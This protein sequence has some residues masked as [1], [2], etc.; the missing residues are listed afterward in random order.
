[1]MPAH[2]HPAALHAAGHRP[3]AIALAAAQ[4]LPRATVAVYASP[5]SGR[6]ELLMAI[7]PGGTIAQLLPAELA[8]ECIV[9]RYNGLWVLRAEWARPVMPGDMIEWHVRPQGGGGSDPLRTILSIALMVAAVALGQLYAP[10]LILAG[11]TGGLTGATV[12]ALITAGIVVAGNL[13]I[14]ALLPVAQAQALNAGPQASPSYN[15]TLSGNAARLDGAIPVLYGYNRS[16]PDFAGQPYVEYDN[17]TSDQYYHA[18]LAVA[19]GSYTIPRIEIDDTPLSTFADVTFAVLEPGEAPT[20]V[21]PAVVS[22]PEVTGQEL[23]PG[24]YVGAFAASAA[25]QEATHLGFDLVL[26]GLAVVNDDGSLGSKSV[27]VRFECRPVDD[28]GAATD[29]W[30]VLATETITAATAD[31]VRRSFKYALPATGRYLA[32]A[33]RTTAKDESRQVLNTVVWAGLRAYLA[34]SAPLEPSVTHIE[35]RMRASE[36]LNGLSQ[37]K[38]AVTSLRKLPTWS[39]GGGWSAPT[40]TRNPAWAL[41]DK[42]RNTVYGDKLPDSRIDLVS[43]KA[44]ADVWDARQDRCDLIFDTFTDSATADQA[45]AGAGRAVV[46]RRNGMRTLVRDQAAD[47]PVTAYS[48]RSMR[49]NSWGQRY[50]LPTS[51]TPDGVIVEYWSNR[52]WD[53]ISIE[54]PA[55]GR[56]YTDT[57]HPGYDAELPMMSRPIRQRILGVTGAT[58]AER[59][60]LYLAAKLVYR[61]NVATWSTELQGILPAYGSAVVLAPALPSWGQSGDVVSWDADTRVMGLSEPPSFDPAG[62]R[63]ISLV[64]DDGTLTAAI[65]ATAG[66]DAWSITLATAPDFTMVL[67][68]ADRERPKYVFGPLTTHRKI[69][70]MLAIEPSGVDDQGTPIINMTAVI[71]DDRVHAADEALLPEDEEEQD[72]INLDP[73][74]SEPG[75]GGGDGGG[76]TLLLVELSDRTVTDTN[77]SPTTAEFSLMSDGRAAQNQ[78]STFG[79]SYFAGQWL[80]IAPTSTDDTELFEGRATIVTGSPT[81]TIGSWLPLDTTRTWGVTSTTPGA[82]VS[83]EILVEIRDVDTETLQAS[84]NITLVA[85]YLPDIGGG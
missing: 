37:R 2:H 14:N 75:G 52:A 60:G 61:R 4:A 31:A 73:I 22:A 38:I 39:S 80:V 10:E 51:E 43:L 50:G 15:V 40:E 8:A 41:A 13:A 83:A 3:T 74:E 63:G 53:W 82:T 19:H 58:H 76:S 70:R 72:P 9:C 11:L 25:Q 84:A 67:D 36:Q 44:L 78:A 6:P 24:R 66:P 46:I 34:A 1:M 57:G 48:A 5:L 17:A 27:S 81:G 20:L 7:E 49:A 30:V 35:I 68:A 56:T 71:E 85:E 77:V 47:L 54:C 59:E 45:L 12:S 29:A 42:W 64:R 28:W 62:D 23:T 33:V 26:G 65:V 32:R 79:T 55:P 21:L 16:Y 69:A 18:L